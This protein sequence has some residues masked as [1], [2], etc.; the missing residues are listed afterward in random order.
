MRHILAAC[1]FGGAVFVATV[2]AGGAPIMA[3]DDDDLEATIAA[4]QTRVAELEGTVEARGEK[5]NAQRT[6]I[7][8]L[9][10]SPTATIPPEPTPPPAPAYASGGLGLSRAE[11]EAEHGQGEG[12]SIIAYEDQTYLVTFGE[13]G[14]IDSIS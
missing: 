7:A 6:T 8:E 1:L 5:I 12:S 2:S 9:R 10:P 4:L 14:N 3:Q 11:W 13:N